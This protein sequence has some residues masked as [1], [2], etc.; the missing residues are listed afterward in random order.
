MLKNLQGKTR[1]EIEKEDTLSIKDKEKIRKLLDLGIKPIEKKERT[2]DGEWSFKYGLLKGLLEAEGDYYGL[3]EEI[4]KKEQEKVRNSGGITK[5]D[6]VKIQVDG[7]IIDLG[8]WVASQKN[9]GVLKKIQGKNKDEIEEDDTLS[10]KEKER[11]YKL[12]D[13]GIKPTE[14]NPE[15]EWNF[16]YDLLKG[17]LETEGDYYGLRE[18]AVK[19]EQEKL[20]NSGVISKRRYC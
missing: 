17:L 6:V 12:L 5:Y 19:K 13:L 10:T 2:P 14:R 8:Q 18:E 1:E 3:K 16:K 9:Q 20:K 4:V 15:E 11:I 7:E